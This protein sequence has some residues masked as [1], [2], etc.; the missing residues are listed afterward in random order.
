MNKLNIKDQDDEAK[1]SQ[2]GNNLL[3]QKKFDEA[4]KVFDKCALKYP[5]SAKAHIDL[6]A[7]YFE[8]GNANQAIKSYRTALDL[9]PRYF[10]TWHFL[11]NLLMAEGDKVEGINCFK[12]FF[13]YDPFQAEIRKMKAAMNSGNFKEAQQISVQVLNRHGS[14]PHA[15]EVIADISN[16]T[17]AYEAAEKVLR[18]G[19]IYSPY[20]IVLWFKLVDTIA[21]L[22]KHEERIKVAKKIFELEPDIIQ[23]YTLLGDALA[24]AGQYEEALETYQRGLTVDNKCAN[25]YYQCGLML[26]TLNR[27][28][29]CEKAYRKCLEFKKFNGGVY[30]ALANLKVVKFDKVDIKAMKSILN[31]KTCP[32]DQASQAGFAL[33]KAYENLQKFDTAFEYYA[34]A[35]AIRPI[36]QFDFNMFN[37]S[38]NKTPLNYPKE[39]L[40]K[41]AS[42]EASPIPIFIVGLPRVGSTLIE[43]ILSSHSQIEGTRELDN[44]PLIS[45]II[46][47]I[48]RNQGIKFSETLKRLDQKELEEFGQLYLDDT[49]I[50][51]EGSPYFIDKLPTNFC[52]VGLIHMIL[53]NAIIIDIRRHPLDAGFSNFKQRFAAGNDFSYNL[54]HIGEYYNSYLKIMDYWDKVLPGKVHRISYE[55]LVKN[56][57]AEVQLLLDHC[58]LG[59]EEN[60][61]K[62][63]QNKRPVNTPSSEQVRQ[64]INNKSI[65]YWRNFEKQ[66]Q[67]MIDALGI[68]TLERFNN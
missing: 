33:G 41:Q 12:K 62:F 20:N 59:F 31:D 24:T 64:P 36:A 53:P 48:G 16:S 43:Q 30:W 46:D 34:Q 22:G 32:A 35:N 58:G 18:H 38:I 60:C 29:E 63:H 40:S 10:E 19:L 13:Y 15:L 68:E 9:E 7:G 54:E 11:G 6:G 27:R 14:H 50:Y 1:L 17:G 26:K 57:D 39:T 55:R 61:L 47:N 51:R 2:L 21:M 49:A 8:I 37:D 5:K 66:L 28:E 52:H 56:T 3:Q 44:L 45:R 4:I 23:S 65:G 42:A 67:P 25:T